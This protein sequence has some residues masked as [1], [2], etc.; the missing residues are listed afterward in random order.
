MAA[1]RSAILLASSA[2][3]GCSLLLDTEEFREQV[4]ATRVRIDVVMP[5]RVSEGSTAPILLQGEGFLADDLVRAVIDTEQGPMEASVLARQLGADGESMAVLVSVP[6]LADYDPGA[7]PW[8]LVLTV[9]QG[10]TQAQGDLVVDPL[11]ELTLSGGSVDTAT[12]APLYSRIDISAATVLTGVGP[13]RLVATQSIR[14]NGA[15]DAS[16]AGATDAVGGAGGP[17]GC[18]GG[19]S[20]EPGQCAGGGAA[21]ATGVDADGPGAG[22][23]GGCGVGAQAGGGVGGGDQ[24]ADACTEPLVPLGVAGNRGGG[25]GGGGVGQGQPGGGGG[26]SGG[27]IELSAPRLVLNAP[28]MAR[29]GDGAPGAVVDCAGGVYGGGGGGGSGGVVLVRT[30][31]LLVNQESL[32]SAGNGVGAQTCDADGGDGGDGRVRLDIGGLDSG[33]GVAEVGD[34]VDFFGGEVWYGP[35]LPPDTPALARAGAVAFQ[36]RGDPDVGYELQVD[37]DPAQPVNGGG[38][39]VLVLEPGLRHVC[40]RVPGE[41]PDLSESRHCV[42]VAVVP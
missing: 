14:V 30:D 39:L 21:G 42:S 12:L 27:V 3:A 35:R 17:G 33:A 8:P 4:D 18:A 29:G 36:V 23:G 16:G 32:I 37:E 20:G 9:V 24:G 31:E 26:G 22:G 34:V 11:P 41:D 28:V 5:A 19:G 7:G 13:A 1:L 38:R 10:P 25:G 15:L 6:V 40:A 2:L